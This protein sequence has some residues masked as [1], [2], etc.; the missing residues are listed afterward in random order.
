MS[1]AEPRV[2]QRRTKIVA[3]LGPASWDEPM[4]TDLLKAGVDV[5]RINCSHTDHHG[6]RAQVA[7]VRRASAKLDKPVAILLD[8]Q[9]PKI[10]VGDIPEPLDLAEGDLL[11][12]VMDADVEGHDGR[13]GTTYP[14]MAADVH[15]GDPVLFDDGALQGVVEAVDTDTEPA[16]VRVR[17]TVGG[18]LSSHKGMNLP[19]VEMSVPS[20]TEKDVGDLAVGVDVGV[21]YVALSFVRSAWDVV[22]LRRA[23]EGHGRNLP[24]IAKIEKP[25]AVA[26][27][28]GILEVAEGVMV[29]RGDLG[30]EVPLERVPVLQKEIIQRAWQAGALVI[31]ATQMLDSMIRNPR[32]TRAETTDVANAILDGTDAVMLS[33]ETATGRHPIEAVQAMNRIAREVERSRFFHSIDP[34]HLAVPDGAAGTLMRSAVYAA[35]ESRRPLV[36]FT[37]S[38]ASAIV[39]SKGRPR[40]PLFALTPEQRVVDRLAL[41]WGVQPLRIAPVQSVDDLILAGEHALLASGLVQPGEELVVLAGKAPTKQA[42]YLLKITEAG[43]DLS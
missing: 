42:T 19:G 39:V 25:Q 26:E 28:D 40:G 36:V 17:M 4:L 21:D 3:T 20:L 32:P 11:T 24:I 5:C 29:A 13:V 16:E 7:R 6:I 27:L 34:D 35:N 12:V 33:G 10:R 1:D 31:T 14:E 37:W 38:G 9:G 2:L 22:A 30:V 18:T 43:R 41:A 8:L 23:L 15:E